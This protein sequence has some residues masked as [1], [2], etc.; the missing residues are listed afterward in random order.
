M[1]IVGNYPDYG[2]VQPTAGYGLLQGYCNGTIS[3]PTE[4]E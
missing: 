2:G 4:A 1:Y 3:V